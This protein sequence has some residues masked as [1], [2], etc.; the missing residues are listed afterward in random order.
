MLC[1]DALQAMGFETED[2]ALTFMDSHF[3]ANW[4]EQYAVRDH[5]FG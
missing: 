1:F 4:R 3:P 5:G 2:A